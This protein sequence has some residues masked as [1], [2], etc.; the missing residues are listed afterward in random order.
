[1]NVYETLDPRLVV[2][3]QQ[4]ELTGLL[5]SGAVLLLIGGALLSLRWLGRLPWA[6]SGPSFSS[7]C[8][9]CRCSWPST[10]SASDDVAQSACADSSVSLIRAALAPATVTAAEAPPLRLL[11]ARDRLPA[12]RRRSP[13]GHRRRAVQPGRRSSWPSTCL[14]A[15]VPRRHRAEPA[16]GG[17]GR[18]S[19]V[20]RESSEDAH[21][22]IVAFS[23]FAEIIQAPTTD[24]KLLLDALHS[25]VTGR[26][27]GVGSGILEAIDAIDHR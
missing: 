20:R 13:G 10:F 14:A 5:A 12:R 19:H 18:R 24:R 26:R 2:E 6:S 11:R 15:C 8:C 25:L 21:I 23:G 4:I 1:M 9:S 3:A 22:G 16:A 17:R 27:T 7:S